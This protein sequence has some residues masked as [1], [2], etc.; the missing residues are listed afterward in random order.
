MLTYSNVRLLSLILV[1]NTPKTHQTHSTDQLTVIFPFSDQFSQ[2]IRS[3]MSDL[4][5]LAALLLKIVS[6]EIICF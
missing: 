3:Q 1:T 2:N 4:I 6:Y 5:A